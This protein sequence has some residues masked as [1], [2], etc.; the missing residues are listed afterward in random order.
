MQVNLREIGITARQFDHWVWAGYL[1]P[2]GEQG[3]G[4]QRSFSTQEVKV[5]RDMA[6][7]VRL[8]F[9]PRTA[10]VL[11]RLGPGQHEVA[12]TRVNKGARGYTFTIDPRPR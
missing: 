10:V 4:H 9:P 3:R 5:V 2:D 7:L 11:A 12:G 6:A 1:H 8:G